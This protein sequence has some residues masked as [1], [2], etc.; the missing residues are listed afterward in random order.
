M[1]EGIINKIIPF[2]S[3]DGPGNRTAI[4]LQG[5]NFNCIYCHNPE[6]IQLCENCGACIG[7]CHQEALHQEDGRV[8]WDKDKCCECDACSRVCHKSS[9]PRTMKMDTERLFEE[10]SLYKRFIDGITVSGGECTL[11]KDFL[12]ELFTRAKAEGLTCMIDTNGSNDFE[13]M[14]ELLDLC[15]GVMLDVKVYNNEK[16]KQ[17]MGC[18]NEMVLK[19]LD[20]LAATGKLYEVRTVVVPDLLD[21]E[22]TVRY[23]AH[24]LQKYNA[25]IRYKLIQYRSMGVKEAHSKQLCSPSASEMNKLKVIATGAGAAEVI[26]V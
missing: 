13:A 15:D 25:S 17:Y 16:H 20:Y 24:C 3:V 23:V 9:S 5:C 7:A 6:T 1:I 18:S 2:S 11:Q 21:N 19:N 10:M 12:V 4:F 26:I 22:E 8:T 14:Q